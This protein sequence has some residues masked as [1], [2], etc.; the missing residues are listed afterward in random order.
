[1]RMCS[2]CFGSDAELARS[3]MAWE[4]QKTCPMDSD[5]GSCLAWNTHFHLGSDLVQGG[6]KIPHCRDQN[7]SLRKPPQGYWAETR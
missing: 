5:N 2:S 4:T 1:M 3:S 6:V 7:V